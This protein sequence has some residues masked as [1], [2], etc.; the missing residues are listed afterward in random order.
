MSPRQE[1]RYD[2]FYTVTGTC[3]SVNCGC[4]KFWVSGGSASF[5]ESTTKIHHPAVM[6]NLVALGGLKWKRGCIKKWGLVG[7]NGLW[8]AT[9]SPWL[10][11]W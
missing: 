7:K 10:R 6:P 9:A 5:V 2:L 8:W 11:G 4:E 1:N 3:K